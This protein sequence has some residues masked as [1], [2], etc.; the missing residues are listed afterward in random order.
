MVNRGKLELMDPRTTFCWS[1]WNGVW[2]LCIPVVG[3]GCGVIIHTTSGSAA[4]ARLPPVLVVRGMDR[5]WVAA[6]EYR[7]WRA[8]IPYTTTG[9]HHGAQDRPLHEARPCHDTAFNS[10]FGLKNTNRQSAANYLLPFQDILLVILG[11]AEA[12]HSFLLSDELILVGV[13][14]LRRG[15]GCGCCWGT[16]SNTAVLRG[17]GRRASSDSGEAVAEVPHD[18]RQ[19]CNNAEVRRAIHLDR[20]C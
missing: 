1:A 5:G 19:L 14:V 3:A 9:E 7:C 6:G 13:F 12:K 10:L 8:A 4:H 2:G 16:A 15:R 17:R 20:H 11:G 18:P